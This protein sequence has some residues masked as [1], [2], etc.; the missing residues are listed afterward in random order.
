MPVTVENHLLDKTVNR[1]RKISIIITYITM[2][3]SSISEE[4]VVCVVREKE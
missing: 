2:F 3:I 1:R 4:C